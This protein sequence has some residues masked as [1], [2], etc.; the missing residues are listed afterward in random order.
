VADEVSVPLEAVEAT[1]TAASVIVKFTVS[2]PS[3]ATASVA[4]RRSHECAHTHHCLQLRHLQ[5]HHLQPTTFNPTTPPTNATQLDA[6]S[7]KLADKTVASSFL[8]T[9][10]LTVTV[11]KVA[12]L[13]R[14]RG[15]I[16]CIW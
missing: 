14:S 11:E 4:V 13:L 15:C 2:M 7:T 16:P 5:P 8:S 9:N 10:A 3:E 1:A 12:T 6:I